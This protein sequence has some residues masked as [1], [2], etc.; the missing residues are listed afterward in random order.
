MLKRIVLAALVAASLSAGAPVAHA[1][2]VRAGCGFETFTQATLTGR[3]TYTGVAYGYAVLDDQGSHTL[4]CYVRVDGW[5]EATTPAQSGSAVVVTTGQ[6]WY[7]APEG[8]SVDL[9]TE[10]NGVTISCG[11]ADQQQVPPQEVIDAL[12]IVCATP[13]PPLSDCPPYIVIHHLL[14]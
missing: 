8:S 7:Y 1:A 5:E 14:P 4:R 11:A 6:V 10:V 2:I 12:S 3:D 9:C 13:P